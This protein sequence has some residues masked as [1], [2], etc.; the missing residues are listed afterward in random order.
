MGLGLGPNRRDGVAPEDS[1][2]IRTRPCALATSWT[3]RS[4]MDMRISRRRTTRLSKRAGAAIPSRSPV[5]K[6][7]IGGAAAA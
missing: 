1:G 6:F 3:I 2:S 4:I 5:L 7:A